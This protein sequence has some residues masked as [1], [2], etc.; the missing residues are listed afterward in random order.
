MSVRPSE[1]GIQPT[2]LC[3]TPFEWDDIHM[4]N[5]TIPFF[6]LNIN[7]A[8]HLIYPSKQRTNTSRHFSQKSL[9][10]KGMDFLNQFQIV[11]RIGNGIHGV[12]FLCRLKQTNEEVV[13]KIPIGL[14]IHGPQPPI[15]NW[16]DILPLII[17]PQIVA[18]TEFYKEAQ[19]GQRMKYGIYATQKFRPD[20]PF[21]MSEVDYM[22]TIGVEMEQMMRHPGYHHVHCIYDFNSQVPCIV[23]KP[24]DTTLGGSKIKYRFFE[25]NGEYRLNDQDME[26]WTR[27]A[28][29]L[30]LAL[31][32][33]IF[34]RTH[35]N[36]LHSN[37]VF[38]DLADSRI[39]NVILG[40]FGESY[41]RA[42]YDSS[43]LTYNEKFECWVDGNVKSR[44]INGVMKALK[45]M[46]VFFGVP[47]N[48]TFSSEIIQVFHKFFYDNDDYEEIDLY[49]QFMHLVG[50]TR[51]ANVTPFQTCLELKAR[52]N[53]KFY[54][55]GQ[56]LGLDSDSP[57]L[58]DAVSFW[59]DGFINTRKRKL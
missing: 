11:R 20:E 35:H 58:S 36:D 55:E 21:V 10:K 47:R 4:D 9:G 33:M 51:P 40:D 30:G 41:H 50:G 2:N 42:N 48:A 56:F 18:E 52:V 13:I 5:E 46:L 16:S 1:C 19:N 31:D 37:A 24:H 34:L 53:E 6:Q 54:D 49:L 44:D 32:Y 25:E 39:T 17:T 38:C 27:I 28:R 57:I 59:R 22:Q 15:L 29:Q 7:E 43:L 8:D 14:V 12:A 23:S 3:M 26:D 45:G